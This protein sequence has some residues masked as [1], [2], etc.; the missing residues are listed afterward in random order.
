MARI[1]SQAAV[2][3]SRV[4]SFMDYAPGNNSPMKGIITR[5]CVVCVA[6]FTERRA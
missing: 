3:R 2:V 4:T 6:K 5:R 1:F